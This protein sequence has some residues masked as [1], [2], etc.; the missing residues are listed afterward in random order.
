MSLPAQQIPSTP[1]E[2]ASAIKALTANSAHLRFAIAGQSHDAISFDG[3]EGI[4]TTFSATLYV[5]AQLDS[6]WLGQPGE[7]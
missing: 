6:A 5:L 4:S 3:T 7:I 1:A 2:A